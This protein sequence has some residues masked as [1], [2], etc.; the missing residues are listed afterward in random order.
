MSPYGV[1]GGIAPDPDVET[2]YP[3]FAGIINISLLN[4]KFTYEVL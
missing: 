3:R 1:N 4:Q 2:S